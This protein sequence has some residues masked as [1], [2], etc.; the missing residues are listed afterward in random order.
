MRVEYKGWMTPAIVGVISF[1]AGAGVGYFVKKHQDVNQIENLR[2]EVVDQS[3]GLEEVAVDVNQIQFQF[4]ENLERMN[5]VVQQANHVIVKFLDGVKEPV[6]KIEEIQHVDAKPT[7]NSGGKS[8]Q[9]SV[10]A[11]PKP[12]E[13]IEVHVDDFPINETPDWH[14]EDE[15]KARAPDRPYIIHRDEFF[16]DE[17]DYRQ[18]TLTYYEGDNILCDD[19]DIPVYNPEKV[20]GQMIF[21]HGSADPSIV[22]IRNEKLDAEYEII[23]DAGFYQ[24]EVL[25]H[26]VE[27]DMAKD[28][29]KHFVQRFRT[30]D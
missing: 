21:G 15:L 17:S 6:S 24:T 23:L 30:T 14:Y 26:E 10:K 16:G 18:I 8:K 29:L 19:Q 5:S 20:V 22:Y 9:S 2:A 27:D 12:K 28:E 13:V 11:Q 3:I 4:N 25:G 1:A 7:T